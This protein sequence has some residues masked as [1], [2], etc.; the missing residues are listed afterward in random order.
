MNLENQSQEMLLTMCA[1]CHRVIGEDQEHLARG[2]KAKPEARSLLRAKE[3]Q[4]VVFR[5]ADGDRQVFA[6]V[7]R[8][9]SP[10]AKEGYDLV[11][12][13]CSDS[14]ADA[15]DRTMK[16]EMGRLDDDTG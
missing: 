8:S 5:L 15:L 12:Q 9:D 1:W 4:V 2:A 10:A 14:C 11:F 13:T 16:Q 3:G 7:P 6:I